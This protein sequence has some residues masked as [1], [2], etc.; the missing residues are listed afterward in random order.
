MSVGLVPVVASVW[1]ALRGTVTKGY[2][3]IFMFGTTV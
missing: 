3:L 1:Y 2:E